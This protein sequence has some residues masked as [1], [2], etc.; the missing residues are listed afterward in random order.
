MRD[1]FVS[2]SPDDCARNHA[3]FG[4]SVNDR[5]PA[6]RPRMSACA[7]FDRE[8]MSLSDLRGSEP[9]ASWRRCPRV[10]GAPV[11]PKI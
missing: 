9:R 4:V 11:S 1:L 7:T 10:P 5:Y 6:S 3:I 2:I 8:T